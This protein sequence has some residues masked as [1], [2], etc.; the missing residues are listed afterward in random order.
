MNQSLLVLI[1]SLLPS[2]FIP[3]QQTKKLLY[4]NATYEPEIRT[5]RLYP[6]D[7]TGSDRRD[8]SVA[9]LDNQR[10]L[11]EFDDLVDAPEDY[12]VKIIACDADWTPNRL[13][14]MDY[15][16]EYNEFNI[17]KY[18]F[19]V[20]T[21]L[22]YIHYTFPLPRVS[23]PGNYLLVA[24]RNANEKEIILS[25]RFM[26]YSDEVTIQPTSSLNGLTSISRT[27]QQIDFTVSYPNLDIK[28]PMQQVDVVIRQN[29]RWNTVISG[30]KPN[31]LREFD[32]ELEYRFFN[33]ENNFA[34]G[35]EYR[36][37]DMR[38]LRYPGQNVA[39]VNRET[40][41]ITIVLGKDKPRGSEV[42]SRLDDLNGNFAVSNSD[43]GNGVVESD[44]VTV[45]FTLESDQP[46]PGRVYVVGLM[47]EYRHE[48]A[49]ELTY[50]RA[51]H[52]Y[53]GTQLLKQGWYNYAYEVRGDTLK[54]NYFEGDHYETENE[55]EIFVYLHP[56]DN[57]GD[58]LVSYRHIT[59]NAHQ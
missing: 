31:I 55:Y 19:S 53:Q 6:F 12:R 5:V 13:R 45:R 43:T 30:L 56:L 58:L 14:S 7:G 9:P 51:S 28:N 32:K 29:Q 47:N 26:I 18:E 22:A 36:F 16:S 21:K 11:L 37:F 44:Y 10:L 41:P 42:Y 48:P 57:R 23:R 40:R 25:H 4:E 34:G 50:D 52:T 2:G 1:L 46:V 39:F 27:N 8:P 3:V 59:L 17:N 38:S 49:N 15:L 54:A 24:Y 20:D 35:S 33:E